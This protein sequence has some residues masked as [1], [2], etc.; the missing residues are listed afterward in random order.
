M[1]FVTASTAFDRASRREFSGSRSPG[2]RQ[3]EALAPDSFISA[4]TFSMMGSPEAMLQRSAG[5]C[6]ASEFLNKVHANIPEATPPNAEN[7]FDRIAS[8]SFG[9]CFRE[10]FI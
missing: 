2:F 9:S 10:L 8:A 7:T 3:Q 6:A 4:N 1:K 5:S